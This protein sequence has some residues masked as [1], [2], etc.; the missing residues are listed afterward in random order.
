MES[1]LLENADRYR[2]LVAAFKPKAG[3]SNTKKVT[4]NLTASEDIIVSTR[5]RPM[6]EDERA[7]GFPE[8]IFQRGGGTNTV[9]VHELRKPVKPL[10]PVVL[11]V[12]ICIGVMFGFCVT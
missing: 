8:G 12:R 10:A 9:D 5:I 1:F 11:T 7:Q 4:D 2:Q 3:A 6:L